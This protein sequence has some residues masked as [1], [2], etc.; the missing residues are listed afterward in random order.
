[1]LDV[2]V[3]SELPFSCACAWMQCIVAV[4][5][6]DF[7]KNLIPPPFLNRFEKYLL[8][9]TD[10]YGRINS[11]RIRPFDAQQAELRAQPVIQ[12]EFALQRTL[13]AVMRFVNALGEPTFHGLMSQENFRYSLLI[14]L[15]HR[16]RLNSL[17]QRA[18]AV[19]AR[20]VGEE[21]KGK[22]GDE[23]KAEDAV[24]AGS[25]PVV[26][27]GVD[28][29]AAVG[30]ATPE[31]SVQ[32][33][34]QACAALLDVA[35]PEHVV[36]AYLQ[37]RLPER[38]F[39][40]Y[41]KS[42]FFT[43]FELIEDIQRSGETANRKFVAYVRTSPRLQAVETPLRFS[44]V[45]SKTLDSVS[46]ASELDR[47]LRAFHEKTDADAETLLLL[48][49]NVRSGGGA[50]HGDLI[51]F[52]RYRV[53]HFEALYRRRDATRRVLLLLTFPEHAL[54]SQTAY[55]SLF[56]PGWDLHFLDSADEEA[57][58]LGALARW[59]VELW[60]ASVRVGMPGASA[61]AG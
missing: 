6:R 33:V 56:S 15:A 48:H 9:P 22:L 30:E 17:E 41:V 60:C 8:L 7:N 59:C 31:P 61:L 42:H 16:L 18:G 49:A 46:S 13:D 21:K 57:R 58:A 39:R 26:V 32:I 4:R 44:G 2:N 40:A 5:L 20:E 24:L 14:S 45:K 28:L 1:M 38:Y 10:V 51:N 23:E 55:A 29:F 35:H 34:R 47:L 50:W 37:G 11:K 43:L 53:D 27:E 36:R 54:R 52:V 3:P 25:F 12:L 19:P